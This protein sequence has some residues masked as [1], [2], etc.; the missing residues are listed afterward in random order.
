M[1]AREDFAVGRR[2]VCIE[3]RQWDR[4]VMSEFPEIGKVY[5]VR[6]C[7]TVPGLDLVSLRL[8][9]IFSLPVGP[10]RPLG[11]AVEWCFQSCYFRPLDERRLDVFRHILANADIWGGAQK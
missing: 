8:V 7:E 6:S 9:E 2:I 10:L 5:T 3:N 4:T 1:S 11:E